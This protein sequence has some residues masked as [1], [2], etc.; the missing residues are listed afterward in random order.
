MPSS[1]GELEELEDKTRCSGLL[2]S[3]LMKG[4]GVCFTV[5]TNGSH[6]DCGCGTRTTKRPNGAESS[7]R[8]KEREG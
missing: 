4:C 7:K 5:V 6:H 2:I 3:S 8:R 1:V